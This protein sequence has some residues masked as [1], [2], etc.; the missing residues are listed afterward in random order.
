MPGTSFYYPPKETSR[1][2]FV[3]CTFLHL[4]DA[5]DQLNSR[6]GPVYEL[7]EKSLLVQKLLALMPAKK[8]PAQRHFQ[9][10]L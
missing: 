9:A 2:S 4:E 7:G 10:L 6:H 3:D 8:K 1:W 5:V